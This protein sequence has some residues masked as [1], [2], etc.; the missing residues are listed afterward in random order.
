MYSRDSERIQRAPQF[1]HSKV[2]IQKWWWTLFY[3]AKFWFPCNVKIP[4]RGHRSSVFCSGFLGQKDGWEP[5]IIWNLWSLLFS[6]ERTEAQHRQGNTTEMLNCFQPHQTDKTEFHPFR[7]NAVMFWPFVLRKWQSIC[8]AVCS[9]L[10]YV[11]SGLERVLYTG[12][13]SRCCYKKKQEVL[14]HLIEIMTWWSWSPTQSA[15]GL[16]CTDDVAA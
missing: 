5:A 7:W 10:F 8:F 15:A 6:R 11:V 2:L 3:Q 16:F 13:S 12:L 1:N 14:I 9:L 4:C